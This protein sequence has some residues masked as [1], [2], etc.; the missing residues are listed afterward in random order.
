[1]NFTLLTGGWFCISVL[2]SYTKQKTLPESN[3]QNL[4]T[5]KHLNLRVR[6]RG[7]KPSFGETRSSG[8]GSSLPGQ[9]SWSVS[10]GWGPYFL[11]TR[12][13]REPGAGGRPGWEKIKIVVPGV[14]MRVKSPDQS[15]GLRPS[16][17]SLNFFRFFFYCL[18]C[19]S[20]CKDHVHFHRIAPYVPKD[21]QLPC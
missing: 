9:E 14:V 16:W 4:D 8:T 21:S 11:V 3:G 15:L 13:Y 7:E 12:N 17:S 1:M 19:S 6:G 2:G 20:Y 18:G 10:G 5:G